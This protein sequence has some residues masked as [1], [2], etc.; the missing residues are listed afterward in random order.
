MII[1]G[2]RVVVGAVD[3]SSGSRKLRGCED[4]GVCSGEFGVSGERHRELC[5]R[6]RRE[7]CGRRGGGGRAAAAAAVGQDFL[8]RYR[9]EVRQLMEGAR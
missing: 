4:V 5:G 2:I 7:G 3:R 8:Y 1:F 6:E 9:L